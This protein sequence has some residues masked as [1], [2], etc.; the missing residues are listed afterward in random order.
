MKL[1]SKHII[2]FIICFLLSFVVTLQV[3]TVSVNNADILRL[4][5]ENELRDEINQWKDAYNNIATKNT[6]LNKKINEYRNAMLE[7]S[8]DGELIKKELDES[9]IVAGLT[10]IKGKGIKITIDVEKAIEEIT[11]NAERYDS[12]IAL[13]FDSD[14]MAIINELTM[15]GAEGISVNN[16]RITN[17]TSIK[18][19]GP[20]IKI[21]GV[22]T[23]APF[24]IEAIGDPDILATN[25]TLNNSKVTELRNLKIDVAVTKEEELEL[26]GYEGIVDLKFAVPL[27]EEGE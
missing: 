14:I 11:L 21:N 3:R 9:N 1:N 25:I 5:K 24:I 20:I 22:N 13:I 19:D 18:G 7:S 27:I 4:K 10:S 2:I 6:E 17:L 8:D 16:Q 15:Y 23:S 26:H 12:S